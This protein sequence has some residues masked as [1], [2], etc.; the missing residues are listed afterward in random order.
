MT[1]FPLNQAHPNRTAVLAIVLVSHL[2]IVLDISIVITGLPKIR[3]DLGFS[4]ADLSWVQNAYTLAFGGLLLLAARAGD[5]IGR[6]RMFVGGLTI[7]T[8]ASLVIGLAPTPGVLLTARAIQGVGAAI[9]AP[10]TLALL[11]VNFPEGSERTRALSLYAAVAGVGASLGLVLGG[12]FAGWLSWRVGFFMNVPIGIALIVFSSR[13]LQ[14]TPRRSGS[15]DILG[16]LVSV[17]GMTTLVYGVV[18]SASAGWGDPVTLIAVVGAVA[19]LAFFVFHEARAD[20]PILPLRLFASAGGRPP[21]RRG[22]YSLGAWSPSVSSPH[23]SCNWC[24]TIR[25]SRPAWPS[26]R[27]PCPTSPQQ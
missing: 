4:T 20:Q 5:V 11:S 10:S 12:L 7:F 15:F 1:Q 14:E 6:R 25:H 21:M 24:C 17:L 8:L 3:A 2:M 26:Y 23:S 16:A 19:L 22:Y 13:I 18:R 9:L 27:R